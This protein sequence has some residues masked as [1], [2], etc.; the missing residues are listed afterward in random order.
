MSHFTVA[1]LFFLAPLIINF[2]RVESM[3]AKV[4]VL[5]IAVLAISMCSSAA[6]KHNSPGNV[7]RLIIIPVAVMLIVIDMMQVFALLYVGNY[8]LAARYV[9]DVI[10]IVLFSTV[11]FRIPY[12]PDN[13][14]FAP[15][16]A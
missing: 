7:D 4:C 8:Y 10:T 11:G 1:L 12:E 3:W 13:Y 14:N 5:A 2:N 6:R 16:G 9:I 15:E